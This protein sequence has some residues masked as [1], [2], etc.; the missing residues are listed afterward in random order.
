MPERVDELGRAVAE[1]LV[2]R[3]RDDVGAGGLRG[4]DG[5]VEV[6]HVGQKAHWPVLLGGVAPISGKA[7]RCRLR[8][9]RV[10]LRQDVRRHDTHP[11]V[12]PS[13]THV[14]PLEA[15]PSRWGTAAREPHDDLGGVVSRPTGYDERTE[16]P[17]AR[18]EFPRARIVE[19]GPALRVEGLERKAGQ[20][21]EGAFVAGLSLGQTR[22]APPTMAG[23]GAR[24]LTCAPPRPPACWACR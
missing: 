4:S 21:V 16:G 10:G 17:A 15:G 12:V 23:S 24:S 5:G 9:F 3:R 8:I 18:D 11:G 22:T 1:E 20:G 2:L 14:E 13:L 7:S 6:L 19:L